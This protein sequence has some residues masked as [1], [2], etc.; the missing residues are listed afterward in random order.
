MQGLLSVM[1]NFVSVRMTTP[2]PK[3]KI[4]D[5]PQLVINTTWKH[6]HLTFKAMNGSKLTLT[7]IFIIYWFEVT[8]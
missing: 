8:P 2:L 1:V 7:T 3:K 6:N 5:L 4:L